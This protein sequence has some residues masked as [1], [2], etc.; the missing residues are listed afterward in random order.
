MSGELVIHLWEPILPVYLAILIFGLLDLLGLPSHPYN[1]GDRL[2]KQHCKSCKEKSLNKFKAY[3][4]N[5]KVIFE[6]VNLSRL[7]EFH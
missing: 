1:A 2:G 7:I 5:K 4:L 6:L 3:I